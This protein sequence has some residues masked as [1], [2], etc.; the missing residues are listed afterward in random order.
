MKLIAFIPIALLLFPC[1]INAQDSISIQTKKYIHHITQSSIAYEKRVDDYSHKALSRF[2]KEAQKIKKKL[3][4][5][6]PQKAQALFN[7]NISTFSNQLTAHSSLRL[8][9]YLDT[10]QLTLKYLNQP[11]KQL[12]SL[13]EKLQM[14]EQVQAY[15]QSRKKEL[16]EQ[17][18]NYKGF[19][20]NFQQLNKQA[21]YYKQQLAEYKSLYEHPSRIETKAIETL[22]KLP[23]YNDFIKNNT[24][25][26]GLFHLSPDYNISRAI[27]GLQTRTQIDQVLSQRIGSAPDAGAA[28]S[29]QMQLAKDK[30]ADLKKNFPDLNSPAEMP[31]FK[32][33]PLK[34]KP[35][36]NA[37]NMAV[38]SSFKRTRPTIQPPAISP[39]R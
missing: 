16:Q 19:E 9:G 30:L 13:Q 38:I 32:P 39:V 21:Y 15:I 14:T 8:S 10:T 35:F 3:E 17:L 23:A 5:T 4:K 24:L 33:N 11:S 29:Q 27:E 26:A 36:L 18:A 28:F 37:L 7:D 1:L 25:L 34:T 22:K 20:K 12:Q 31:D 6:D 2:E